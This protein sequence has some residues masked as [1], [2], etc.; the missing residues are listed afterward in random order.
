M[1]T[2]LNICAFLYASLICFV[3]I[4][5]Y[6]VTRYD[7]CCFRG[8]LEP[9]NHVRI[10]KHAW[11]T[12]LVKIFYFCMRTLSLSHVCAYACTVKCVGVHVQLTLIIQ[13][14]M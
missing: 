6:V 4:G 3:D 1:A 11:F 8:Y 12:V 13:S 2:Y 7:I 10:S 14:C 9:V 5:G